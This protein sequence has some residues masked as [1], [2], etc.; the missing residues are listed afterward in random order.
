MGA[1]ENIQT[2][3]AIYE[4]FGRG[5]LDTILAG[6]ADD[7]DWGTD[8]SSD[9]APWWGIRHGKDEV[10]T[11]FAELAKTTETEVF[12][13][14]VFASNDDGDVLTVVHFRTRMLETG[15]TAEMN[16]HHWFQFRDG[17]IVH[18][19]GTEDTAVTLAALE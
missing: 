2:V 8:T 6:V 17:K 9:A 19:R 13:P 4:A 12:R 11:F 1:A 16:L 15:K 3:K 7:V 14:L 5:D 18:Y 10:A